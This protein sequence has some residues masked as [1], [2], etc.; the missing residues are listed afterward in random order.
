M[1]EDSRDGQRVNVTNSLDGSWHPL[2]YPERIRGWLAK[3]DADP[4]GGLKLDERFF[5]EFEGERPH[6]VRL[7]GGDSSSDSY[8]FA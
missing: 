6:Q 2:F 8:C 3:L 4:N 7:E 1:V 5:L